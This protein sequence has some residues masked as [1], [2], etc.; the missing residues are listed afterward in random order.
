MINTY[1]LEQLDEPVRMELVYLRDDG[2]THE[3]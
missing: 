1:T 3:M 2:T